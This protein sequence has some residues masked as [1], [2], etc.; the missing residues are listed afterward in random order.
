MA[1]IITGAPK[2][3]NAAATCREAQLPPILRVAEENQPGSSTRSKTWT[4]ATTPHTWQQTPPP[5]R[6]L[7]AHGTGDFRPCFRTTAKNRLNDINST[8]VKEALKDEREPRFLEHYLLRTDP[9]S[10]HRRAT[11]GEFLESVT[12]RT[13]TEETTLHRLR[14]NRHIPLN[15]T[16]QTWKHRRSL[17]WALRDRGRR[18]YW[19]FPP[20]LPTMGGREKDLSRRASRLETAADGP[21]ERAEVRSKDW[22]FL[23]PYFKIEGRHTQQQP[24]S[25][26]VWHYAL[27][28]PGTAY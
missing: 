7:K 21:R 8:D 6:R 5:R 9:E 15:S 20:L 10:I 13:R 26:V 3:S 19:A 27:P 23:A 11:G 18:R 1:R 17:V 16:K 2:G 24:S 14:L 12:G 25:L 22:A 4:R 28:V